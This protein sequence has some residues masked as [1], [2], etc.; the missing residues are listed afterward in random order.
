MKKYLDMINSE[1]YLKLYEYYNQKTFMDVLGV[2][3][4]ENEHSNFLAW[5]FNPDENHGMGDYPLRKL[6]Q[7]VAFKRKKDS[8]YNPLNTKN[9]L[10]KQHF[11]DIDKLV[12]D[13]F[14]IESVEKDDQE[15]TVAREKV[16]GKQ[17]R[18]DIFIKLKIKFSSSDKT[19]TINIL[20]E[21]KI[22]SSENDNQTTDYADWLFEQR[23][24]EL[25]IPI[26]LVVATNEELKNIYTSKQ[27][28][29]N[30]EFMVLNYQY[31]MDGVFEP[32]LLKCKTEFG[33][34]ILKEYMICL[35]KALNVDEDP[36]KARALVMAISTY[37]K[38]LVKVLW[39]NHKD[40]L[41][42]QFEKYN[43][44]KNTSSNEF[45]SF[46]IAIAE[47]LLRLAESEKIRFEDNEKTVIQNMKK[48]N[49]VSKTYVYNNAEYKKGKRD[50]NI[51]SL[52]REL[53][54][55]YVSDKSFAD[56]E[57]KLNSTR[58]KQNYWLR[59][60]ILKKDELIEFKNCQAGY[61][62]KRKTSECNKLCPN[63]Q[64]NSCCCIE[65]FN[66]HFFKDNEI[67]TKKDKVKFYVA[68]YFTV[69]NL[70]ELIK[71]LGFANDV[72]TK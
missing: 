45:G 22:K 38:N 10:N 46:Y 41:I 24:D 60:I 6:L 17:R 29:A 64:K 12:Y 16:I 2:S 25:G 34:N 28:P 26:Y 30:S 9:F 37:E 40:A 47:T 52:C 59:G 32:C 4:R 63:R 62:P 19:E 55:A 5:L 27:K 31:L 61:D 71:E 8:N 66:D 65:D 7:T 69:E 51:G 42:N 54:N 67:E 11:E 14:V 39:E 58:L 44:D 43:T 1:E 36:K 13:D 33:K 49:L 3:R 18:L 21:N 20:I 53:I 72:I 68:K 23:P 35:G 70:E 48:S 50:K 56:L 15:K 57:N